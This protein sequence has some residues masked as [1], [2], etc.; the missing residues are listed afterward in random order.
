MFVNAAY[1]RQSPA[2]AA[3]ADD[4]SRPTFAKEVK[5]AP[6]QSLEIEIP[7]QA[8][9]NFGVTFMS[10][11]Q[12]SATLIDDKGGV[13]GKSLA[14]SPESRSFFRTIFVEQGVSA[15][16]WKLRF[17]NSGQQEAVAV[18]AAWSGAVTATR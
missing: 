3:G 11:P 2:L 17:E 14:D 1:G 10:G 4:R 18:I 15:G 5:L 13:R 7:V 12:V 16:T 9:A 8:G 6:A